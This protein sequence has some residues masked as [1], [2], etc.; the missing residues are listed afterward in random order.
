MQPGTHF[1]P[2]H[3]ASQMADKVTIRLLLAIKAAGRLKA[4]HFDIKSAYIHEPFK[5]KKP[6]FVKQHP[7]FDGSFKYN[8]KGG[9]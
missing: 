7:R 5:H 3:T 8:G 4:D 9:S 1:S 2:M 6:V